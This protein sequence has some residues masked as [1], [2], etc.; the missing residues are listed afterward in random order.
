MLIPPIEVFTC[1]CTEGMGISYLLNI[2]C[3]SNVGIT[4]ACLGRSNTVA[5]LA[6]CQLPLLY[7]SSGPASP[8]NDGPPG[9]SRVPFLNAGIGF[10]CMA[11]IWASAATE[12]KA[13]NKG[14]A[15]GGIV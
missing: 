14:L 4:L 12:A 15:G 3:V 8:T 1:C 6:Y 13:M 11:A 9:A 7:I 5:L 10:D 2:F